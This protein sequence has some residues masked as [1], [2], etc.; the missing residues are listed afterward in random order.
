MEI[1]NRDCVVE[2]TAMKWRI[3][4][5]SVKYNRI[6]GRLRYCI[7]RKTFQGK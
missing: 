6:I 1:N 4:A 2:T 3:R 5:H 7:Y